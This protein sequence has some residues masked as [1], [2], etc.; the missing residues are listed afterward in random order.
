MEIRFINEL[1]RTYVTDKCSYE[2]PPPQKNPHTLISICPQPT[3]QS[4]LLHALHHHEEDLLCLAAAVVEGLLD[5]DQQLVFDTLTNQPAQ[6]KHPG[7]H[8]NIKL[9]NAEGYNDK[10]IPILKLENYE[11]LT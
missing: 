10:D 6:E 11:R 1:M 5:G 8:I 9:K 7:S 4:S 3:Y 2:P